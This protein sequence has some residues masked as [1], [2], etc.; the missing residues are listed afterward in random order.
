MWY[1]F[2]ALFSAIIIVGPL[3][4]ALEEGNLEELL[5]DAIFVAAAFGGAYVL[6]TYD[7][8]GWIF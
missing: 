1:I 5:V 6:S 8:W 4:L 2:A 3:P 7:V